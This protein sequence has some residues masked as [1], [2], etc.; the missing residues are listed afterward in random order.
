[1]ME[2]EK[3]I[4]VKLICVS[5]RGYERFLTKGKMYEGYYAEGRY[6][7]VTND[8]LGDKDVY[9]KYSGIFMTVDE[10]RDM[11]LNELGI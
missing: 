7:H 11:K 8:R 9:H 1:M 10:Y 4:L 2:I 5:N 3:D 6:Y